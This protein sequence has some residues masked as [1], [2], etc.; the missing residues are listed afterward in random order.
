MLSI[1][2]V[3]S[4]AR[5]QRDTPPLFEI[6]VVRQ[7]FCCVIQASLRLK[8]HLQSAGLQ[9]YATIPLYSVLDVICGF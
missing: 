2:S 4:K 1:V 7:D 3:A 6:F 5:L 8:I 9:V